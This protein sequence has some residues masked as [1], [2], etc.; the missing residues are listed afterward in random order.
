MTERPII[1]QIAR[2]LCASDDRGLY[3]SDP[4]ERTPDDEAAW[5]LYLD[6]AEAVL[7]ALRP[8]VTLALSII[9]RDRQAF[10]DCHTIGGSRE[11]LSQDEAEWVDEY[12]EAI[13]ALEALSRKN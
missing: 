7:A 2:T 11:T 8:S 12:D 13:S 3:C 1:D 9:K 10:F 4:D 6:Q 5:T